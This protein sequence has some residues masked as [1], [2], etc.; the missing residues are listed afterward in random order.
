MTRESSAAG[1]PSVTDL[2]WAARVQRLEAEVAGLRRAMA[3]RGVIEQAKGLLAERLGTTPELAF[4][5]MSRTSQQTNVRLA[6]VAAELVASATGTATDTA[7]R[8]TETKKNTKTDKSAVGTASKKPSLT[9][10]SSGLGA[11]RRRPRT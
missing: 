10:G 3:S 11:R 2:D 9:G 1:N 4:E 7:L 5:H 8:Q 6:D